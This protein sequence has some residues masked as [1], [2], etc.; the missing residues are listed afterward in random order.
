M[1]SVTALIFD[2]LWKDEIGGSPIL[3][4]ASNAIVSTVKI[5]HVCDGVWS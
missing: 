1:A 2:P 4:T 3:Q 5:A